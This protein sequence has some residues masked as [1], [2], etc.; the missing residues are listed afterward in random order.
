VGQEVLVTIPNTCSHC[1][2]MLGRPAVIQTRDGIET[3]LCSACWVQCSCEYDD[4]DEC[5]IHGTRKPS[6][7]EPEPEPETIECHGDVSAGGVFRYPQP[8]WR[9]P[10]GDHSYRGTGRSGPDG[11]VWDP[12]NV[13]GEAYEA[14]THG[15]AWRTCSYCGSIHPADLLARTD[16]VRVEWADLKYGWPHKLYIDLP[17]GDRAK[18]YTAHF[19]DFPQLIE[20]FNAAFRHCGYEF[21]LVIVDDQARLMYRSTW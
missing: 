12:C 3:Y 18:F 15:T 1:G 11:M 17:K 9:P 13:C 2:E 20:P 10:D 21:D 4:P 8:S 16:V 14:A 7:P 19:M 6:E 5:L